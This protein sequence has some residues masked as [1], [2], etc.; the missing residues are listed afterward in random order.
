[1]IERQRRGSWGRHMK[2]L[3]IYDLNTDTL[4]VAA[5]IDGNGYV[6]V[7]EGAVAGCLALL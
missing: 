4:R 5:D 7:A 1:M 3:I 6:E 2:E